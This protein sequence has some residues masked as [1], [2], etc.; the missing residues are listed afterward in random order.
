MQVGG[1]IDASNPTGPGGTVKI[2]G[3]K[4][5]LSNAKI[6]A[7]GK[8]A[9]GAILVGGDYKGGG[10]L[11]TASATFASPETVLNA[12][13]THNGP[14]G[15]VIVWSDESTRFLGS[16]SARG[17]TNGGT[18]GF[19]ET[20]GGFL[21]VSTARV[22]VAGRNGAGGTWLLD[23]S[24]IFVETDLVIDVEILT[25]PAVLA[26]FVAAGFDFVTLPQ[27]G[28]FEPTGTQSVVRVSQINTALNN[29]TSVTLDASKGNASLQTNP[30]DIFID[31]PILKSQA[32]TGET[33]PTLTLIGP[34][35]IT[36]SQTSIAD[37]GTPAD[38][39][40][41]F[42]DPEF[43]GGSIIATAG[44]LNVVLQ[45]SDVP[46]AAVAGII[47][48]AVG[49]VQL[50]GPI[51]T[52]GG[53]LNATVALPA[54]P[55]R[56]LGGS[57]I[58]FGTEAV[59]QPGSLPLGAPPTS[60]PDT[61]ALLTVEGGIIDTSAPGSA[62]G[63]NVTISAPRRISII[64][65]IT[66]GGGN[67]AISSTGPIDSESAVVIAR[68][69]NTAAQTG[70]GG[71]TITLRSSGDVRVRQLV[72]TTASGT[73]G[74]AISLLADTD[75]D[76]GGSF[77]LLPT[78]ST[79]RLGQGATAGVATLPAPV[80]S[81]ID[82]GLGSV[83]IEASD[84]TVL[85]GDVRANSLSITADAA[86]GNG[87]F[88]QLAGQ[89]DT[90]TGS[91]DI[92][93]KN[94]LLAGTG[95][96]GGAQIYGSSTPAQKPT[97]V[98][99]PGDNGYTIETT[100]SQGITMNGNVIVTRQPAEDINANDILDVGEDVNS[101]GLL[102]GSEDV[103]NNGLRD[104]IDET[105]LFI[106]TD[107]NGNGRFDVGDSD[108]NRNGQLDPNEDR[109]FNKVLDLGEDINANGRLDTNEDAN[110][111]LQ[112]DAGEDVNANG[113][114]DTNEFDYNE[115][116]LLDASE[117][118]NANGRF[119]AF[120][121][122]DN[123]N[124]VLDLDEDRNR[125]NVL[126]ASEDINTNGRL[127][128]GED[129]NGNNVLDADSS[130][131]AARKLTITRLGVGSTSI[132]IN[133]TFGGAAEVSVD[134][135]TGSV[136][137]ADAVGAFQGAGATERVDA[138]I[139]SLSVTGGTV[140]MGSVFSTGSVSVTAA[141]RIQLDGENVRLAAGDQISFNRTPRVRLDGDVT[142]TGDP[143]QVLV[144]AFSDD[145]NGTLLRFDIREANIES[146]PNSSGAQTI[147][148]PRRAGVS[149]PSGFFFEAVTP[150][151]GDAITIETGQATASSGTSRT[152]AE[153]IAGS[154]PQQTVQTVQSAG[155]AGSIAA[156]LGKVGVF[157]RELDESEA[158][159]FL[160]LGR[161]F[162]DDA[163]RRSNYR[164]VMPEELFISEG[165]GS[166]VG[167]PVVPGLAATDVPPQESPE[168]VKVAA[169]RIPYNEARE[170]V[171]R[172]QDLMTDPE[173]G[174]LA[175]DARK[176]AIRDATTNTWLKYQEQ[177][178]DKATGAGYRA[179]IETHAGDDPEA[180]AS[181]ESLGRL[182]R[183]LR[184]IELL[185]LTPKELNNA[186]GVL[187]RDIRPIE[188]TGMTS[189]IFEDAVRASGSATKATT[190]AAPVAPVAPTTAP[191]N[192]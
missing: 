173:T 136:S 79:I 45:T 55:L 150:S 49:Q 95:I 33:T 154:S 1:K 65:A 25:K 186:K 167:F 11:P 161:S 176:S 58:Q 188:E 60:G 135:G 51:R 48:D 56:P 182:Q 128:F 99:V 62:V 102:D 42:A 178:G 109:N 165:I 189:E 105:A 118:I 143:V 115:N 67:V 30:G 9:G 18:G 31:A 50:F 169:N 138:P 3:D 94:F 97:I 68:P 91:I 6:D 76:G 88:S 28:L 177:A 146:T 17:G 84:S 124:G 36:M 73:A 187:L 29:G 175:E 37:N 117:D 108:L 181:V 126:D 89:I 82:A 98:I 112:L 93:A 190:P 27:S 159:E 24:D 34:K 120:E 170:A 158:M 41:D 10:D 160:V 63:G 137:F 164:L 22:D 133:G 100:T 192:P 114:L 180:N 152:A 157:A 40:D 14:G 149:V 106:P 139:T 52:N 191:A 44:K 163:S 16:I 12:D 83:T 72:T 153:V 132:Q 151:V 156:E 125:N 168:D 183:T 107:L 47:P 141:D 8:T 174:E 59:L 140:T 92:K 61:R 104:N 171:T 116:R 162:Y 111:N 127:D 39:S 38:S 129:F 20:S 64:G 74:G 77:E 85:A 119:D 144:P 142:A 80:T 13:A 185:G 148:G 54:T 23:P 32:A 53:D 130:S 70:S 81:F 166:L 43:P 145:V 131:Q 35:G 101:N 5:A 69:I 184:A 155:V 21:D 4:I 78:I 147:T 7:S 71:G 121:F 66:T 90:G 2:L 123:G 172:Y 46:P 96:R 75:R 86:T 122:D 57:R 87:N 15:R 26:Q 113:R 179:Y 103:N 19:V 110:G 134:G